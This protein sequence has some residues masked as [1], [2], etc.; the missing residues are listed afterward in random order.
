MVRFILASQSP[1]RR[2]LLSLAGY[3]Y[4]VMVAA[5]D[6]TIIDHPDPAENTIQTAQ[7]KARAIAKRHSAVETEREIVI[8]ADTTVA[9]DNEMLGKPAGD[10]EARRMLVALR[11]RYHWV[12][13]GVALL[14]LATGREITGVHSARVIMRPYSDQE[15]D[16]YIATGDPLDKAGAY[17][18]QHPQFR[19]V[20]RLDGCY[21]G[22]MGISICHLLQLLTRL[23]IPLQADLRAL[24]MAHHHYACPLLANIC[25]A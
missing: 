3:P 19:P 4:R 13:T 7:L 22:V 24:E 5:V 9:L 6:E 2:E 15:I 25:G 21:L 16:R 8:G 10:S 23:Q 11:G 1:R 12:H 20:S 18:I 14:D 17:A